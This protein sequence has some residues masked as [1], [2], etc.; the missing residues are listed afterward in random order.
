MSKSRMQVMPEALAAPRASA[1][2]RSLAVACQRW[3]K[4]M[5]TVEPWMT[6]TSR[7]P[8]PARPILAR[9]TAAG[10]RGL[11]GSLKLSRRPSSC[12]MTNSVNGL[13]RRFRCALAVG[14]LRQ[15][16]VFGLEA[17]QDGFEELGFDEA[18]AELTFDLEGEFELEV[19]GG[20]AGVGEEEGR[21]IGE[22][23]R[24]SGGDF[25]ADFLDLGEIGVIGDEDGYEG[26]D[27]GVGEV[28]VE[29]DAVGDG[30]IGDDNGGVGAGLD[31]GGAP[32][33]VS[34]GAFLVGADADIVTNLDRGF[35]EEVDAGEDV[36]EGILESQGNG[37][38]AYAEG[39][40]DGGDGDAP[41]AK[42]N[43]QADAEDE[44]A[45]ECAGEAGHGEGQAG[46]AALD[47][48]IEHESHAEDDEGD[49]DVFDEALPAGVEVE[50]AEAKFER[51]R[52]NPEEG[53]SFEIL[54]DDLGEGVRAGADP[55]EA[56]QDP[57]ADDEQD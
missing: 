17:G 6:S 34:N 11:D 12:W 25:K 29:D 43:E 49:D 44:K 16:D 46:D 47:H 7:L 38:A 1:T 41:D 18:G 42:Q 51:T 33:D 2:T 10:L 32:A 56:A 35:D 9:I 14:S 39:R 22:H 20:D 37:E 53:R 31:A 5:A 23:A 50:D 19:G 30:F 26:A 40:E 8:M 24:N 57:P 45:G 48:R 15:R 27:A 52:E 36:A 3:K 54:A 21:G 28:V 4:Q 13:R 55:I